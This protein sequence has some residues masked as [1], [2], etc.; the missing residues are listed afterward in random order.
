MPS[1]LEYFSYNCNFMGILAGPTCSYNDY[2]AFIEGEPRRHRELEA[3]KQSK[4]RL[5]QDEPSPNVEVVRKVATSFFCLLVFLS[6][7][8]VF[9]VERNIDADF[10]ANTPFY[11]QVVYLYLSMLTTR[12]KSW[13][14]SL[15]IICIVLAVVMPVKPRHLRLKEQQKSCSQDPDLKLLEAADTTY[16]HKEKTS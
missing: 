15:H 13:Y 3:D 1:L 2:I 14:F 5:R 12:P 6:V 9:P 10:I 16:S 11:A 8:K 7:C 4:S